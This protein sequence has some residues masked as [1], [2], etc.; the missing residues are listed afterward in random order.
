MALVLEVEAGAGAEAGIGVGVEVLVAGTGAWN[1][2]MDAVVAVADAGAGPP[3]GAAADQE[4]EIGVVDAAARQDVHA[5]AQTAQG[6][7]GKSPLKV[8]HCPL[9]LPRL[10]QPASH[11]LV[12]LNCRL[13]SRAT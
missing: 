4:A 13:T 11:L 8:A 12:Q 10:V 3:A 7:A 2:G 5:A 9:A 1:V 6:V